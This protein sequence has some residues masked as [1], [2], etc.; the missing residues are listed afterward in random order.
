MS[1]NIPLSQ[2]RSREPVDLIPGVTTTLRFDGVLMWDMQTQAEVFL[3]GPVNIDRYA[4][5]LFS[6]T[7]PTTGAPWTRSG[8]GFHAVLMDGVKVDKYYRAV[9]VRFLEQMK[10]DLATGVY[11]KTEYTITPVGDPPATTYQVERKPLS[12]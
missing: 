7:N 3:T 12:P 4:R 6:G 2:V 8:V 1:D 9:G 11:L 5:L 10:A